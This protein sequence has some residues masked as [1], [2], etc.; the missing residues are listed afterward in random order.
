MELF[1]RCENIENEKVISRQLHPDPDKE[2]KMGEVI[3]KISD[4]ATADTILVTDVGQN[5]MSSV[6][7]FQFSSPRSVITSGGLG[8]M[9]FGIPAA[10]GA[11]IGCPERKVCLFCGDGGFQMTCQELGTLMEYHVGIKIVILNNNFLGNVRQ[12]QKLFFKGRYS[13]TPLLNPDFI[14]LAEAYGIK[15][16]DVAKREDLDQ[17]VER[18]F[19]TDEPYVLNVKIDPEDNVFPMIM[20]GAPIDDIMLDEKEKLDVLH[21]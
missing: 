19:A 12:W 14:K 8:T 18:M 7:Y 6:R 5:Q 20:P 1:T 10:A 11:K 9:G 16:E 3:R 15:G 4:A 13:Q 17:A 21:L 2:M